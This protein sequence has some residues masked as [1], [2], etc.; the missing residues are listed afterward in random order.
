MMLAICVVVFAA[1]VF[2]SVSNHERFEDVQRSLG[3]IRALQFVEVHDGI[4]RA[5]ETELTGPFDVW[6]GQ[7]WRIP[8][9]SFHHVSFLHLIITLSAGWYLGQRL[10]RRWS[11]FGMILF[12]IPAS[13]VPIIAELCLGNAAMGFSGVICAMLGALVVLRIF[14]GQ[15][16][17]DFP[18]EA[19]DFGMA[20]MLVCWAATLLELKSFANAA[21]F[22]GFAYGG[23]VAYVIHG[24]R[25]QVFL[26]RVGL[27]VVHVAIIILM[28]EVVNPQWNGRYHWYQSIMVRS[29]EEKE[30]CLERALNRDPTLIGA[31]LRSAQ[32]A[33]NRENPTQ[34]WTRLVVGLSLNP[35]SSPLIDAARKMWRHFD[36]QQRKEAQEVLE[37]FFGMRAGLWVAQLRAEKSPATVESNE[38]VI[39]LDMETDLS[40]FSLE[41]KLELPAIDVFSVK[42][43]QV[44][45]ADPA[46]GNDAVEGKSL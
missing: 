25:R 10:E 39:K 26:W 40:K 20:L 15:V 22:A 23:L 4:R 37:Q 17:E 32:I 41:Q 33:E 18:S 5:V 11:R 28:A 3:A 29:P 31:W 2:Q 36:S 6:D 9:T 14:D 24:V 44:S 43:N 38:N 8:L 13:C 46:I 21:H 35:S 30:A 12:L 1:C 34:A 42:P 45:P 19:A 7:W 27:A 16:A